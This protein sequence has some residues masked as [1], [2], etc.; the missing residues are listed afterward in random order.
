MIV[1]ALGVAGVFTFL[2]THL[3]TVQVVEHDKWLGLAQQDYARRVTLAARRGFLFDRNGEQLAYNQPVSDLVADRRRLEDFNTVVHGLAVANRSQGG[4]LAKSLRR[5]GTAALPELLP[6]Y[7]D[8]VAA[9]LSDHIPGGAEA[10][11]ARFEFGDRQRAVLARQLTPEMMQEI[12]AGL[13]ERGVRGLAFE[14]GSSRYYPGDGSLCHVIG[15]VD[16]AGVGREGVEA[17][18]DRWLA[19]E[20]GFREI[21]VDRKG[22]ELPSYRGHEKAPRHGADVHLTI[23]SHLQAM[24]ED[25]LAR[26]EAE[27][28][29]RRC[30]AVLMD[31]ATGDVL[32][33][34]SRPG[35][36]P[37]TREGERRNFAFSDVYEPGSTFKMV[38]VA[39]ALDL[40]LAGLDTRVFC[41][42][43]SLQED[44]FTV[45]D[46]G[47]Y[48]WLSVSQVVAKSSNVGAYKL[49]KQV[50]MDRYYDYVSRFGFGHLTGLPLTS[51][52]PGL[53]QNKR[54][55][56][57]DF[58]RCAFGY[59]VNVTPLQL[60]CAYSAL[61][62]NGVR[63]KPRLVTKV[64]APDGRELWQNP[65]EPR[66]RV[67]SA[68]TASQ[69]LRAMEEVVD[70]DGT[71]KR[72]AIPGY[73]VAGKT[74]TASLYQ[75]GKGYLDGRWV[76]S[77]AGIVPADAPRL[78][79]VMVA[80][81]PHPPQGTSV[82]GGT[83]AGPIF[84]RIGAQAMARLDV[85]PSVPVENPRAA[86]VP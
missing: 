70:D 68:R 17:T 18:M 23:D 55:N 64:T 63:M 81:D 26:G 54:R 21:M 58:S 9:V 19:G 40:G 2:S 69:V 41:H 37:N 67:V 74:G 38:A 71:G 10:I 83:I 13:E 86:S 3:I 4:E 35:F 82:Y 25:E 8:H 44:G 16:N 42:N 85:P 39:A 78:V 59:A 22:R 24:V 29:I 28:N 15:F 27:F 77:F 43:G 46:H 61:A 1:A 80:E 76:C 65:P 48:G 50:G 47:S 66:G 45:P 12:E 33:M 6:L 49:A 34:A 5:R 51:E 56:K 31:P 72:A 36:N 53:V 84:A 75:Q 11:R 60:A 7:Y 32:A 20:P 57:L 79:C 62:N 30:C 52:N 73:K 14:E